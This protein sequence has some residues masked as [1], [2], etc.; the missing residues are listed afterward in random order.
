MACRAGASAASPEG[1]ERNPGS[2]RAPARTCTD[3]HAAATGS[4]GPK[5][6]TRSWLSFR[7]TLN[8][9]TVSVQTRLRV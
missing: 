6:P 2:C 5:A 1:T 7:G 4:K 8:K 3:V 9:C